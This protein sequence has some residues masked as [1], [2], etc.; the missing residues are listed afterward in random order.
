MWSPKPDTRG[1]VRRASGREPQPLTALENIW[2]ILENGKWKTIPALAEASGLDPETLTRIINFL[3]RWNF[4]ETQRSPQL[5]VRRRRDTISP[6]QTL[7]FLS[8][9]DNSPPIQQAGHRLAERIACRRCNGRELK[10]VGENEVECERCHEMQW[11]SLDKSEPLANVHVET[12]DPVDVGLGRRL[13]VRLGR[14]QK[15]FNAEIP[16]TTQFYW[17]R[18]TSCGKTST[19]YAHG[20]SKHLT[21][22]HCRTHTEF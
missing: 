14:P 8:E 22:P 15:A 5:L 2:R 11:Y 6:T 12:E 13:L 17:F 18:C 20:H 7:E 9:I 21:C 4:A 3:T 10:F 16:K 19:D 1:P